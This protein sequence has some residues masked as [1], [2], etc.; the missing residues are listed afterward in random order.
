M[1]VPFRRLHLADCGSRTGMHGDRQ[2]PFARN[3]QQVLSV[4][5]VSVHAVMRSQFH[6]TQSRFFVQIH[7]RLSIALQDFSSPMMACYRMKKTPD[8][9][10]ICISY[11]RRIW[12]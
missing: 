8:L 10:A 9:P 11:N 5:R 4:V 12:I 7:L 1:A 6:G 3:F 2:V